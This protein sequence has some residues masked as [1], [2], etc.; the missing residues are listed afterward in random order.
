MNNYT[1]KGI[2]ILV[3]SAVMLISPLSNAE[4]NAEQVINWGEPFYLAV[5]NERGG[6]ISPAVTQST[7][8]ARW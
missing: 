2:S 1:Y 5:G 6:M 8:T 4:P 7:S 3:I